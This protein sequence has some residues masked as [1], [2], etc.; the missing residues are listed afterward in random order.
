MTCA[1]RAAGTEAR[2]LGPAPR[3]RGTRGLEGGRGGDPL[4]TLAGLFSAR[5]LIPPYSEECGLHS[6]AIEAPMKS[7]RIF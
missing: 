5:A 7:R 3:G 4:G 6:N 2:L 1:L